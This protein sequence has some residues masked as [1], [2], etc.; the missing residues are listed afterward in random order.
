MWLFVF[1]LLTLEFFIFKFAILIMMCLGADLLG[2]RGFPG[3]T[4][5]KEPACQGRGC[6]KH[7]FDLWFR[8]I[9][10]RRKWQPTQVFFAWKIPWTAEPGGL[11][12]MGS[13]RV[14]HDWSDLALFGFILF[15]TLFSYQT[16]IS[17]SSPRLRK[18]SVIM[19]SN[20]FPV[21]PS[22]LFLE[23]L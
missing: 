2:S 4:S 16:G 14:R 13:Q 10:W 9:L 20:N 6:K 19:S 8:K 11:Q 12:S 7:W 15:G 5:S 21:H 1:I 22:L 3:G 17:V 23:P 18:F